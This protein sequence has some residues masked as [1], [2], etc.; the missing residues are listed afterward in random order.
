MGRMR[1]IGLM[2]TNDRGIM[3]AHASRFLSL[4]RFSHTLFALPFALTSAALAWKLAGRI[5]WLE[6]VGILLCMAFARSAAM[7]FNR[8]ADRRFDAENPRTAGRHLPSGEL[9]VPA[10][11]AFTAFNA[12]AFIA[13]TLVFIPLGNWW[14]LFLSGPCL[15]FICAYSLTKRFTALCHFW[16]GVSLFLSPVAAWIAIRGIPPWPEMLQPLMLGGAVLFWVAGFDIFYAC[17]DVEFDRKAGLKSVPATLGVQASLHIAQA[18]HAV[19]FVL[20]VALAFVSEELKVIYRIGLAGVGIL[21]LYEH[22][23]VRADDLSR[24]NQAFFQVN[25]VIS[26]GLFALVLVQL[27]VGV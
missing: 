15:L 21:L 13:S 11:W 7:A 5:Q 24:V 4:I 16:L 6:V 3:L 22:G 12:A 23:L 26:L 20:L 1:R 14:P 8:L 17:Q 18:C 27:A 9:S 10:V 19:M 25:A 2:L